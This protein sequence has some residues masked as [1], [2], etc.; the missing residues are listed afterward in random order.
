MAIIKGKKGG[1]A[2]GPGRPPSEVSKAR[3]DMLPKIPKVLN[4]LYELVMN[5]ATP[6]AVVGS[7]GTWWVDQCLGRASQAVH[8]TGADKLPAGE[9]EKQIVLVLLREGLQDRVPAGLR[10]LIDEVAKEL[11]TA[12][13][14]PATLQP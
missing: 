1:S 8:V 6:A 4:R 2:R 7:V 13:T 14:P 9:R 5:D 10:H 11:P 12:T 3:L